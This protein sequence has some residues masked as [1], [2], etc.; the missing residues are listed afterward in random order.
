MAVGA[1]ALVGPAKAA[2][3]GLV[4]VAGF[5]Q[6]V[7]GVGVSREGRIFVNFPRWETR[8]CPFWVS[9]VRHDRDHGA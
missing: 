7:T 4:Q 1:V 6:Q 3:P 9:W 2:G 5:D 8:L